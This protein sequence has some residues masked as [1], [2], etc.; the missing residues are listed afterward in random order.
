MNKERQLHSKK[1]IPLH[2][3]AMYANYNLPSD[4]DS[5]HPQDQAM[6]PWEA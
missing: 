5:V 3:F 1:V 6:E 2:W 4:S